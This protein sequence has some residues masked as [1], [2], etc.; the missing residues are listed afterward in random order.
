MNDFADLPSVLSHQPITRRLVLPA[1][2]RT[3]PV[4]FDPPLER[5]AQP[6]AWG[7]LGIIVLAILVAVL[8][9]L[10]LA[11]AKAAR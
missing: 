8:L 1:P 6:V 5:T 10:A 3:G 7:V 9:G 4:V 2:D 11:A